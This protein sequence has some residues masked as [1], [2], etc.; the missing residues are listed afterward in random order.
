MK[1]KEQHYLS[2]SLLLVASL[3]LPSLAHAQAT[4]NIGSGGIG[5]L[6]DCGIDII[7]HII[8]FLIA[9]ALVYFIYGVANFVLSAGEPGEQTKAKSMIAYGI[10]ALFVMVS[11]WGLV[12]VLRNTFQF[13]ST[14]APP[15][16]KFP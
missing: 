16:P 11:V 1:K 8:P 3:L 2:G 12:N 6:F 14:T 5:G 9:L 10:I 4:C 7:N 13:S 15:A